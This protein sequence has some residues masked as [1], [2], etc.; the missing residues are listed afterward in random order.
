MSGFFDIPGNG[1]QSRENDER[2][3]LDGYISH[4]SPSGLRLLKVCPRAWQQRYIKGR[5]E[6]PGEALVL[7]S[8]VHDALAYSHR[9]KV[10]S[11]ADLPVPQVVEYFHDQSWPDTVAKDGGEEEIRWDNKPDDVRRDGERVTRAYHSTVSPRVQPLAVERKIEYV[12]PGIAVPVQGFIDV[13]EAENLIDL[14]TG[15]QVSRKPDANWRMQGVLYS[16]YVGKATH[17]HSVSRAKTPS[18]ATPLE[19]P[20]MVVNLEEAQRPLIEKVLRDYADQ[21]EFYFDRYGPE[22][23]WPVTGLFQDYRGGAACNFCGFR[24]DCPAWAHERVVV[25]TASG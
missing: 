21:V 1:S 12:V 25:D 23:D 14:K 4:L 22:D 19:S 2:P 5:K 11:F 3:W 9:Q 8:A 10:E 17:F 13:E 24:S 15:K 18:I 7:G 16:A 20:D 6:R